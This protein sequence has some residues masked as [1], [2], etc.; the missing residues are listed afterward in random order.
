MYS[1]Q[2]KYMYMFFSRQ[3]R[4]YDIYLCAQGYFHLNAA[5]SS[6]LKI[7]VS[8]FKQFKGI[9]IKKI[10]FTESGEI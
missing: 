9:H 10:H 1:D 4:T 7:G 5:Q 6:Q 3:G 2:Y 8:R